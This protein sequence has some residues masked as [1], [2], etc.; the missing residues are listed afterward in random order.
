MGDSFLKITKR[1]AI[2]RSEF[3]KLTE[4]PSIH[5]RFLRN[6]LLLETKGGL[7]DLLDEIEQ[8]STDIFYVD[9]TNTNTTAYIYFYSENDFAKF[10]R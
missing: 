2:S 8:A 7:V 5:I 9:V 3:I 10:R 4:D 6:R 1:N